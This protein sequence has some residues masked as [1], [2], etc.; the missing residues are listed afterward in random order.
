[1][2]L[3]T[4]PHAKVSRVDPG[5][6]PSHC[7]SSLSVLKCN[8]HFILNISTKEVIAHMKRI[9]PSCLVLFAAFLCLG[10][11]RPGIASADHLVGFPVSR[12]QLVNGSVIIDGKWN[13]VTDRDAVIR[14]IDVKITCRDS[15]T[16]ATIYENTASFE[17]DIDVPA[18]TSI[19]HRLVID[20]VN[21]R[22]PHERYKYHIHKNVHYE[23]N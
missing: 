6:P 17:L 18:H 23:L 22:T 4:R 1:M 3:Q 19:K 21:P 10:V 8:R 15:N 12:I 2:V 7:V 13:N 16:G 11:L 9:I 14:G 5:I 20:D